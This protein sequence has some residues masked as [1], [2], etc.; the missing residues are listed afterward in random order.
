M[1]HEVSASEENVVKVM[2]YS[3]NRTTRH[4]VM[5]TV[6]RRVAK[7]LPAIEWTEAATWEAAYLLVEENHF[8]LLILDG[9][10]AKLGG[11]GFGKM[12]RDELVADMPFIVLIGRPQ[13]EW[14][15]RVSRPNAIVSFPI[16]SSELNSAVA[17][18]LRS[19]GSRA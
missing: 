5:H 7:D 4:D 2:V 10:T 11:I 17:A 6:G 3:D 15:A 18:I 1:S 19:R 8:D 16:E 9:E 13:D 14:L 12:V